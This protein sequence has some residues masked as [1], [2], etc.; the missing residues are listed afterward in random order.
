MAISV[1]QLDAI[2]HRFVEKKMTDNVYRSKALLTK[3]YEMRV[4]L[5]GGSSLNH[6]VISGD[7]DS[8]TGGWFSGAETLDDAEK[9]DL[10]NV[11]LQWKEIY[12]TVL[13]SQSDILKN[14]GIKQILNL[15]SSKVKIAEKRMQS[16]ISDGVFSDG[17]NTKV[18]NGLE[19]I[20]DATGAYGGLTISDITDEDGNNSW[21]AKIDGN[22]GTDRALSLALIQKVMGDAT[23]GADKPDCAVSRQD[24]FN[25]LWNLLSPHQRTVESDTFSG[26]GHKGVLRF[27]GIDFLVDSHAAANK[28]YFLNTDYLKLYVHQGQD[29][30]VQSFSQLEDKNAIKKRVLLMGNLLCS[31]RRFQGA[32]EDISVA[33]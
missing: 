9:D 3:L 23:E 27:N 21:L 1:T 30:K 10:T 26:L 15:V 8:T 13:L 5:D 33:S 17:T 20:V 6:P 16:R 11:V 12:E 7:I 32:I 25:E 22:S 18:F 31:A 19:E 24:V 2:T 29:M 14:N 4:K 28:M